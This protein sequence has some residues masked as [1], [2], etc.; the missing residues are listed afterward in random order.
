MWNRKE[1]KEKAKAATKR[2]YWKAVLVSAVFTGVIAAAGFGSSTASSGAQG[3]T[4]AALGTPGAL[5]GAVVIALLSLAIVVLTFA[6]IVNP[7]EVGV[8]QF[9]LN[10]LQDTGHVSD[11]GM[12]FDVSY[13]RNVKTLFFRDLYTFL[14]LLLFIVPG[15][16]KMYE[17]RMIPYLLAEHPNMSKQEAFEQSKRMMKGN[18]WRSFVLDVSFV[19]WGILGVLTLGIVTVLWVDPYKQLTDAA[20]YNALKAEQPK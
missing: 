7:F 16:I 12:G 18:K 9:R 5:L 4:Q 19:L 3:G 15:I 8:S 2:N 1:L 13:Q 14:W 10:A 11:M 17:Y 6:L 20:L